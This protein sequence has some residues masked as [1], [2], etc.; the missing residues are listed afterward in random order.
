[1]GSIAAFCDFLKVSVPLGDAGLLRPTLE[2]IV[3]QA[4]GSEDRPG[5]FSLGKRGKVLFGER[6]KVGIVS[7]SGDSLAQL[8]AHKLFLPLLSAISEWPHRVTRVDLAL[9]V[10]ADAPEVLQRLYQQ[11]RK[12]RV[13]LTRKKLAQ[14]K[15]TQVRRQGY[16]DGRET[17]TVY[18][19]GRTA[20]V[21][22]RVYDKRNELLDRAVSEHGSHP[23]VIA[24]NDPG[25]LTR[26]EV[27]CG[28]HVGVTLRDVAEP[29]ALFWNFASGLLERPE[30][31]PEWQP[32][33]EGFEVAR[34]EPNPAQQ[35]HLLLE[36][37]PDIKRAVRLSETLGH[38]P[39]E[40]L[41]V[42]LVGFLLHGLDTGRTVPSLR[43]AT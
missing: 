33:A 6:G 22:A 11:A 24:A 20:D 8:R 16:I 27:T 13:Q 40:V 3:I 19:G 17:G 2:D 26:Y 35:L 43:S 15:I 18:L 29:T 9:D 32:H 39:R 36:S 5:V 38:G 1:M 14:D 12:G 28:R 23:A 34:Y 10:P 21:C 31:I 37:S 25:P 41:S 7:V 30:G 42:K 4:G